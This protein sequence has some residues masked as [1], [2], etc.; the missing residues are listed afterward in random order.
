[1]PIANKHLQTPSASGSCTSNCEYLLPKFYSTFTEWPKKCIISS[2]PRVN[3]AFCR[4]SQPDAGE[5]H[6]AW[7]LCTE[8]SDKLLLRLLSHYI[9]VVSSNCFFATRRPKKLVICFTVSTSSGWNMCAPH[10]SHSKPMDFE[11]C[12][13]SHLRPLSSP[14]WNCSVRY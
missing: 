1:M 4:E 9:G 8:W 5:R 10:W 13:G 6:L 3:F 2:F 7:H 14:F 12:C 11:T